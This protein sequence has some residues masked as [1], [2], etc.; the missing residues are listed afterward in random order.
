MNFRSIIQQ[1]HNVKNSGRDQG[2]RFEEIVR[3][4]LSHEPEYQSQYQKV[5]LWSQWDQ[6]TN[7]DTGIDI[8][9]EMRD[10]SGFVAVQCKCY[11]EDYKIQKPDIDSFLAASSK[12]KFVRRILVATTDLGKNAEDAIQNQHPPVHV[13][14]LSDL[15]NSCIDWDEYF[16][17]N[18]IRRKPVKELRPHQTEA[19][20]NVC[21]AFETVD[22]GQ[23]IMACGTGKTFTSLKIAER[24][25][26]K[27]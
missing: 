7:S 15:E 16:R 3:I 26:G 17:N 2:T 1:I 8:V 13:I 25:A 22:R 14:G 20:N 5:V 4:Y 18:K 27:G 23:L 10:G 9:A 11:G 19:V 21:N 12:K 24:F 6:R